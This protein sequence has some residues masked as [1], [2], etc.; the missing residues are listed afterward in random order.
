VSVIEIT[1][2]NSIF[3]LTSGSIGFGF[4]PELSVTINTALF[5]TPIAEGDTVIYRVNPDVIKYKGIVR[6][7]ER[8]LVSETVSISCYAAESALEAKVW[9]PTHAAYNKDIL[10]R[11]NLLNATIADV[12]AAEFTNNVTGPQSWFSS[13]EVPAS[14]LTLISG[15]VDTYQVSFLS[16]IEAA[17]SIHPHVRWFIEYDP[18]ATALLP[19]G[20][21]VL[22]N[23]KLG[24]N[25]QVVTIGSGSCVSCKIKED[26]SACAATINVY[27][28]GDFVEKEEILTPEWDIEDEVIPQVLFATA[29]LSTDY[30]TALAADDSLVT[31]VEWGYDLTSI[32]EI[33]CNFSGVEEKLWANKDYTFDPT[34]GGI[35]WTMFNNYINTVTGVITPAP[36][37]G[38]RKMAAWNPDFYGKTLRIQFNYCGPDC[39]RLYSVSEPIANLRLRMS[40]VQDPNNPGQVMGKP[41]E[42]DPTIEAFRPLTA[43]SKDDPR[44]QTVAGYSVAKVFVPTD[45]R[46]TWDENYPDMESAKGFGKPLGSPEFTE[47]RRCVRF[48]QR[49][50][51]SKFLAFADLDNPPVGYPFWFSWQIK[52]RYT[53]WRNLLQTRASAHGVGYT[54]RFV[55]ADQK[56]YT[57][58]SGASTGTATATVSSGAVTAGVVVKKGFGYASAPAVTIIGD[59]IGALAHCTLDAYGGIASIVIDAGGS[60][61]TSAL[62]S[63]N[64]STGIL[65]DDTSKL[66]TTADDVLDYYGGAQWT[67]EIAIT[68][69]MHKT[70]APDR[71]I[72]ALPVGVGDKVTLAGAVDSALAASFI[73]IINDVSLISLETGVCQF[74]IGTRAPQRNPF[75]PKPPVFV[76]AA[77]NG[78]LVLDVSGLQR[79]SI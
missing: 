65:V 46:I 53:A 45:T 18:A 43:A 14:V 29:P 77:L 51:D 67:G 24:R 69:T 44:Y 63:I 20:K 58:L 38:S 40:L 49:Q 74:S 11:N 3:H 19:V 68:T 72:S 25:A 31:Y 22:V 61:Y 17:I 76:D 79:R 36:A 70:V 42:Q 59:G 71:K 6:S 73:G 34:R 56:K 27:G 41:S 62:I 7:I 21:L 47:G 5:D 2:D 37:P 4:N 13:I 75:E 60:G 15:P 23:T 50:I 28:A 35:V 78:T 52:C 9:T 33:F 57:A 64:G 10:C 8:D 32:P 54:G 30:T 1:A 26:Y 39:Y 12:I 66:V 48:E 55:F 16:L